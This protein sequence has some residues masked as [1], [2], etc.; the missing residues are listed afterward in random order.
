MRILKKKIILEKEMNEL[1]KFVFNFVNLLSKY[2][3]YVIVSG[4]VAI[5]LGRIRGT[6]DIDVIITEKD[7]SEFENL[8]NKI[9]N[10]GYWC[11]NTHDIREM[12]DLLKTGRSIRVA[13]NEEVSPNFEIKFAKS[14][15]DFESLYNF[16]EICIKNES[17]KVAP[18]ELQIAYKEVVLKSEKDLEDAKHIRILTKKFIDEEKINNYKKKLIEWMQKK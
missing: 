2:T 5:I 17:I 6:D 7:R 13:K 3:D 1:D 11:I 18:P 10:A 12:Y 4:Y 15:S 16:I 14:E 9:F 8:I